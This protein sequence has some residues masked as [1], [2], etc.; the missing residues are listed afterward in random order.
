M[1]RQIE[2]VSGRY[3]RVPSRVFPAE[4]SLLP[5]EGFVPQGFLHG[6]ETPND[7]RTPM[8]FVVWVLEKH[9]SLDKTSAVRTMLEIH[10]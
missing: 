1:Q 2:H 5:V 10:R 9:V 8:E 3:K 4:T 6:I 7:D